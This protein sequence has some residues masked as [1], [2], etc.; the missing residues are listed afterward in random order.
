MQYY[1]GIFSSLTHRMGPTNRN[2]IGPGHSN[3]SFNHG[4]RHVSGTNH[5]VAKSTQSFDHIRK[6]LAKYFNLRKTQCSSV[7]Q[8]KRFQSIQT[9]KIATLIILTP[10]I[11]RS[12]RAMLGF[13]LARRSKIVLSIKG[14]PVQSTRFIGDPFLS[15][16]N[17]NFNSRTQSLL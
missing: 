2:S 17:Q 5:N 11:W 3:G 14:S 10:S 12:W 9:T 16:K 4:V 15:I 7:F 8:I 13:L 1:W 6:F